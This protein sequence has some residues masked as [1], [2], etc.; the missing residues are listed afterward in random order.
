MSQ[1][2]STA[3]TLVS[4]ATLALLASLSHAQAPTPSPTTAAPE[5]APA[6]DP[7]PS[8]GAKLDAHG[9]PL[10]KD[11]QP[12]FP[13]KDL[14]TFEHEPEFWKV[15]NGV[16]HGSTPGTKEHHYMYTRARDYGDF[17]LHADVK[18]VGNNSGVCIR[19]DPT[20]F[21]NVP[22]YQVDMGEGYWGALWDERGRGMLVPYPKEKAAQ[23][24][25]ANEWNHYYIRA[26]GHHVE[27][28]LNGVKTVD[29]VDEGGRLAG[30]IG[31]QLCHGE[32]RST[33]AFF[34]NLY[35]RKVAAS[36]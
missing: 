14:A 9:K 32:G 22:G 29:T 4:I 36:K 25:H 13:G 23:L 28:W 5:A 35:V 27:V 26:L 30:P 10:G 18:L 15:E 11:W 33:E 2:T 34:K 12:L 31:F 1:T 24:V 19:I 8:A 3:R 20:S 6:P 7:K 21:D 16:I 17:E